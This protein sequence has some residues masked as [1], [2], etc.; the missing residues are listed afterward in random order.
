M[1]FKKNFFLFKKNIYIS[2]K[3]KKNLSKFNPFNDL[4]WLSMAALLKD[5]WSQRLVYYIGY[6]NSIKKTS[7]GETKNL[8]TDAGSRSNTILERLRDFLNF[9]MGVWGVGRI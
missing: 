5:T 2:K 6:K 8:S 7:I 1:L 4:P 3:N 9:F